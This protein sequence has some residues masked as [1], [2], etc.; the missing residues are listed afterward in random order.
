MSFATQCES[1]RESERERER[2]GTRR[3][4]EEKESCVVSVLYAR[5]CWFQRLKLD[6]R[7]RLP[8]SGAQQCNLSSRLPKNSGRKIKYWVCAE[9]EEARSFFT[10]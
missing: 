6:I 8:M 9:I 3:R 5:T 10:A 1:L 7:R 4:M 2:E